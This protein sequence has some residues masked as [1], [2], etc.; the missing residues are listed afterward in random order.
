MIV[1][2][3]T[4]NPI[5]EIGIFN[6]GKRLNYYTWEAN[7]NLAKELLQTI[8]DLLQAEKADWPDVTGV[9]VYK[10]PGSFTGL[11]IGI[12]VANALA[13]G[14]EVPVI[15]ELGED[16]LQAGIERAQKGEND[17]IVLPH[18]GAEANITLP[19]K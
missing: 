5:A 11:R 2:I 14:R 18:Y 19:K 4:D 16:W 15:G 1:T 10:G 3:K 6:D 17:R 8:H 13:Y 7:R 12:T 9:V